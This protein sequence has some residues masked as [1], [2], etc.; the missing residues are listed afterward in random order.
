MYYIIVL[1]RIH[2]RCKFNK[3]YFSVVYPNARAQ[4]REKFYIGLKVRR[5][6]S[7]DLFDY[8]TVKLE[9]KGDQ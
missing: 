8:A 2:R 7:F 1:Y 6:L 9:I 3:F 4:G 5:P